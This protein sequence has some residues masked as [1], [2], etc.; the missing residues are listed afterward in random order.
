MS[1]THFDA[2][3]AERLGGWA[4]W[5][6]EN[7]ADNQEQLERLARNLRAC[8][9]RELTERQ[10]QVLELYFDRE[11]TIPQIA[12]ALGVNRSTVSRTLLRAKNRLRQFLQYSM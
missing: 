5:L 11:M 2:Q 4:L 12:Q 10:R 9:E 7:S 3:R 8:R 1:D 6:R